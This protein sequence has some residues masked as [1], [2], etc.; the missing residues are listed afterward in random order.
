MLVLH[1]FIIQA[2][3]VDIDYFTSSLCDSN[4][5]IY[6]ARDIVLCIVPQLYTISYDHKSHIP[7][8]TLSHAKI[9]HKYPNSIIV[10]K[11]FLMIEN[12]FSD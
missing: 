1:L 6:L 12:Y 5:S 4:K 3:S 2:T 9:L 10:N 7:I 8:G 11:V